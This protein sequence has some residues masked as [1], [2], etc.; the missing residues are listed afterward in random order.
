MSDVRRSID[1]GCPLCRADKITPWHHED[2]VCWIADCEI[3][4]TPM[5]VWRSHGIEPPEDELDHMMDRLAEVAAVEVGPFWVDS[6]M[7]NI[8]DH[9]HAHARPEG[10]FFGRGSSRR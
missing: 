2:V 10:G 9:F 6:N 8:P 1:P 7:R 5:V 4:A 3:C